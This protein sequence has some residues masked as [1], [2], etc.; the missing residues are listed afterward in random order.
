[1]KIFVFLGFIT[2]GIYWLVADD[3][4][5]VK[6][7]ILDRLYGD[8]E[9]DAK[10]LEGRLSVSENGHK[11]DVVML[12]RLRVWDD[13]EKVSTNLLSSIIGKC[14]S[15]TFDIRECT[16]TLSN[17]YVKLFENEP[18]K[19]TYLSYNA[20]DATERDMRM[21]TWGLNQDQ[22][23]MACTMLVKSTDGHT[24][25]TPVCIGPRN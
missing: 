14:P 17:R 15:C 10:Y 3:N 25:N 19:T 8:K 18:S 1:M 24:Q 2:F 23:S 16:N 11:L 20:A 9:E 13:C 6:A 22:A 12:V 7:S 4:S 21:F 5:L